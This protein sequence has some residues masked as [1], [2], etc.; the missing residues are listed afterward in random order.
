MTLNIRNPEADTLARELARIDGTSIT[1]CC[2][3]RPAGNHTQ[4]DEQ[5]KPDRNGAKDTG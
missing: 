3:C 5:G 4:P 1:R 2:D